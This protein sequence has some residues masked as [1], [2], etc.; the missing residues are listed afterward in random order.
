MKVLIDTNIIISAALNPGG[1]AAQALFKALLSPYEPVI[2]DY[3]ID[4]LH[5]KFQEKFP[6]RTVELEAFLYNAL[7]I[8]RVVDTPEDAAQAESRI[9]DVKDRP[10]LRAALAAGVDLLLTGDADFLESDITRP[11][12]ISAA[13]FLAL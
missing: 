7:E 12:I 13:D 5:R 10:I 11:R 6:H 9:R 1:R 4:E 8:I 3:I 2:C